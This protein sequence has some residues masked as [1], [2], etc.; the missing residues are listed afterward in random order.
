MTWLVVVPAMLAIGLGP[1]PAPTPTPGPT[2]TPG[3]APAIYADGLVVRLVS[4]TKLPPALGANCDAGGDCRPGAAAGDVL[5]RV[6]IGLTATAPIGLDIVAGTAGGIALFAGVDHRA[7]AIDCGYVGERQVLCTDSASSVPSGVGPGREVI[8]SETF[9]VPAAS[10]PRLIVTVQPP[11]ND[12]AGANPLPTAT[13]T[14]AE[15]RLT[16]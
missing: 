12:G 2:T 3:P 1:T 8:L 11:V 13:F 9:D 6:D 4:L 16:K 10:L 14:D 15:T 7:A 5:V